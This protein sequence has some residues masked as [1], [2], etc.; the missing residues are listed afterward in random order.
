[1]KKKNFQLEKRIFV[2][3]FLV[4]FLLVLLLILFEWQLAKYGIRQH[5]DAS[6]NKVITAYQLA[7]NDISKNAQTQLDQIIA[8]Q[9]LA[10]FLTGQDPQGLAAYLTRYPAGDISNIFFYDAQGRSLTR[11]SWDLLEK[12]L[13]V[14]LAP[15]SPVSGS[16]L[17]NYSNRIYNVSYK[18][19]K[20]GSVP[21]EEPGAAFR[22][23]NF[24]LNQFNLGTGG[25]SFLL[26]LPLSAGTE[27]VA[28]SPELL[29]N[30]IRNRLSQAD[31]GRNL[32]VRTNYEQALGLVLDYDLAGEPAAVFVYRYERN[33]NRFAQQSVL[34]FFILM[35]AFT[36]IMIILM[37]QWF[38]RTIIAPVRVVSRR[39]QEIAADPVRLEPVQTRYRGVLGEMITAFNRMNTSLVE[40]SDYLHEYKLITD[41]LDSGF[42]WLDSDFRCFLF[43]QSLLSILEVKRLEDLQGANLNE[44]FRLNDYQLQI[45]REK[46]ITLHEWEIKVN[47]IR[48]MV[49]LKISP[50]IRDSK[51][52]LVGNITDVTTKVTERIT[53]EAMELELIKS[54]R[55]AEIGR[56]VEG[57]VHNINS[58]LN[59]VMGY[60]QLMM[61]DYP[62][63]VELDKILEATKNISHT[64]KGLLNKTKLDSSSLI[65]PLDINELILQELELCQ[66]NLFFKHHVE[67]ITDFDP[68]LAKLR[69][70]YGDISLC[71]AN[72]INN[73]IE[74]LENSPE[75]TLSISTFRQDKFLG[76]SIQDSGEGIREEN[77][78]LIFEP[79]YTTKAKEA[80]KG[81]GFGLGLAISRNI[82]ER[83]GGRITVVSNPGTGSTFTILLPLDPGRE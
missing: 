74:T 50:V 21:D 65:R 58:P 76:I 15:A 53:R 82:A 19:M 1:M 71:V 28:I 59:T 34:L 81:S 29:Q 70:V 80:G 48:K 33:L 18:K 62:Q 39:M 17:A 5:E 64:V 73:A 13:P 54:N 14:V 77:L 32:I 25:H 2:L 46:G 51:T 27:P 35:L 55:L 60:T 11:A 30:I 40:Y 43:N 9:E 72:L 79:Y 16:F 4:T 57:I 45:I 47:H 7:R 8:D 23:D 22:V 52:Y 66:H 75:K 31:A 12:Y 56:R 37:G 6:I 61:K 41:S 10:G 44:Y 26:P 67:L 38:S 20:T 78:E 69:A 42:F 68:D 36:L 83:Y 3:F 49:L 63:A 24:N